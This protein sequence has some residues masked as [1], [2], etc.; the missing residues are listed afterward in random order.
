[1]VRAC[2]PA[3]FMSAISMSLFHT[4]KCDG[5]AEWHIKLSHACVEYHY[6]ESN[7]PAHKQYLVHIQNLSVLVYIRVFRSELY[8][9]NVHIGVYVYAINNNIN[10][11]R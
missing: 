1:M 11:Y 8:T 9:Y 10:K 7:I 5:A 6:Y 3:C 2:M 4:L